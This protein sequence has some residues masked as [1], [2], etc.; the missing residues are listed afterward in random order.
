MVGARC[1][2]AAVAL[3]FARSGRSV[4]VLE[5]APQGSTTL[6]T[7]LLVTDAILQLK[8]MGLIEAVLA[9]GAPRIHTFLAEFGEDTY[10]SRISSSGEFYISVRRV[11][12]DP[13]I[14]NA[15]KTAGAIVYHGANVESLIFQDNKVIGVRW[16][17]IGGRLNA[18]FSRLVIGAD[19]RH[20][21]IARLAKS[22]EYA[23][24][25]TNTGAFYA[26]FTSVGPSKFGDDVLQFASGIECDSLC[27]PCDGD[28]H[29]ILLNLRRE[30]FLRINARAERVF[31]EKLR[32]IPT[33]APRLPRARRV[34]PVIPV[35][36]RELR[37]FFRV[38]YG[39]GWALVGDSG[40]RSHPAAGRGIA[41]AFRASEL[42]HD[43]VEKAWS[44]GR[45]AESYLD[46]Y[47][48]V[49]DTENKSAFEF[50]YRLGRVN[51]FS[52]PIILEAC[53]RGILV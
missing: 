3:R 42:L 10:P 48:R 47:W 26:Y 2:G 40:Y 15:A 52:D 7:H 8:T 11:R 35:A 4:L 30:E 50:S 45:R 5:K 12:L 24:I 43:F 53:I 28:L 32:L 18:E 49:R 13:I 38:P 31:E 27:F 41:E 39:E 37:G 19:G 6:S 51:P 36:P 29:V 9:T 44:E 25:D 23:N 21:T 34:S 33:L 1:A 20:S 17:G 46:E 14:E 22:S 16:R